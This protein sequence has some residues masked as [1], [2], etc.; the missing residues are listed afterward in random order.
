MFFMSALNE[1]QQVW[2]N[3]AKLASKD[4]N[5]L[6]DTSF[7]IPETRS[8]PMPD[9]THVKAAI[10]MFNHVQPK[11]ERELASNVLKAMKKYGISTDTIGENNKL[12]KY[13]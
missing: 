13:V 11:Y 12:K 7:G 10:R 6:S 9:A 4:R 5:A 3:E 1:Q 8:Y 2:I